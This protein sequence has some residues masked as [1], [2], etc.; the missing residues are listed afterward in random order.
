MTPGRRQAPGEI[1]RPQ[2]FTLIE[3]LAVVLIIGLVA[4][5]ALPN[6]SL[7]GGRVVLGEAQR[8]ASVFGFAR[9][10]AVATGQTHRVVIDLDDAGYWVEH[11]PESVD[12]FAS[13]EPVQIDN[14][15]RRVVQLAAPVFE[16][17]GFAPLGGAFGQP[18]QL[19]G[20]VYFDGLLTLAAG[21]LRAGQAEIRFEPDGSADPAEI[22]L[23]HENGEASVLGLSRLA[24]EVRIERE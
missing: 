14:G 12:R 16:D 3:L 20:S 1:S 9:Q 19:S 18:H 7:G 21:E 11:V 4:G 22:V 10:R 2:G 8:L 13:H 24:D 17:D 23:R 6:L 15:G 5:I